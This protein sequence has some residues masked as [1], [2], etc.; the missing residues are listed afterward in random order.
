[1]LSVIWKTCKISIVFIGCTCLF[2]FGLRAMHQEYEQFHRYDQ[3]E[4]PAVKVFQE[5][6][7]WMD[8]LQYFFD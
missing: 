8:R 6:D 2:Y 7:R 3:P 4:G 5:E 1:M